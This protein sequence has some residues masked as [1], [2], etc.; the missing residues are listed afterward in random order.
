VDKFIDKYLYERKKKLTLKQNERKKVN[1]RLTKLDNYHIQI[2][3]QD[4][5]NIL[6]QFDM[7][8]LQEDYTEWSGMLLGE[9]GQEY[10]DV[11]PI[12]SYDGRFYKPYDNTSLALSWY[13]MPSGKYEIVTYLT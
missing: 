5:Q 8:M 13:T 9:R 4:I 11:G 10:F 7:I 3:I 6:N 1:R 12:D 2:P